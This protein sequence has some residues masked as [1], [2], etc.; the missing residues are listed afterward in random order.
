MYRQ[1]PISSILC[2]KYESTYI[3]YTL[4]PVSCG[5][6]F[7]SWRR[8]PP[9]NGCKLWALPRSRS[10]SRSVRTRSSCFQVLAAVLASLTLLLHFIASFQ[11]ESILDSESILEAPMSPGDVLRRF[12]CMGCTARGDGRGEPTFFNDFKSAAVHY[13]RSSHCNKTMRGINAVTVQLNTR[14]QYVGD[15]EARGGGAPGAWRPQP[16]PS[17]RAGAMI[18]AEI[19]SKLALIYNNTD[20]RG[21]YHMQNHAW[22]II[23]LISNA[24]SYEISMISVMKIAQES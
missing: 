24:I 10:R 22:Y 23:I 17:R 4:N 20:I 1:S 9:R 14:P 16:A 3:L 6:G 11:L 19:S 18:S 21:P 7:R 5:R 15:G 8:R 12:A 13:S 2:Y